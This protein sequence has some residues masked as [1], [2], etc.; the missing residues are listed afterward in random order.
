MEEQDFQTHYENLLP[1]IHGTF[2]IVLF[3]AR[4]SELNEVLVEKINATGKIWVS[5]T[6]WGGSKAARIAVANWR[7][8]LDDSGEYG[9]VGVVREVLKQVAGF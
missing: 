1:D 2:M 5:G 3:R 9:G 4:D 8:N 6:S 7:V